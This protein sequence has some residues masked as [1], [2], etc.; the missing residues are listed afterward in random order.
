M[1]QQGT[2]M[3]Q[4]G[5]A[6]GS[7]LAQQGYNAAAPVLQQGVVQGTALAQQGTAQ[8]SALAQQGYNAA[9]P[10]L[11]QGVAQGSAAAVQA[12]NHAA[13]IAVA[14]GQNAISGGQSLY[15]QAVP[16]INKAGQQVSDGAKLVYT[17]AKPHAIELADSTKDVLSNLE[18]PKIQFDVNAAKNALGM[19][20]GMGMLAL[21]AAA[22]GAQQAGAWAALQNVDILKVEIFRDFFQ[23]L[24]IYFSALKLPNGFKSFYGNV[25]NFISASFANISLFAKAMTPINWFLVFFLVMTVC[26]LVLFSKMDL[27]INDMIKMKKTRDKKNWKEMN[28]KDGKRKYKIIKAMLFVLTSLYVPVTRNCMDVLFCSPTYAYSKWE[29]ID[30]ATGKVLHDFYA[31]PNEVHAPHSC[32]DHYEYLPRP[33]AASS[34]LATDQTP[35]PS[36]V[37]A[38]TAPSAAGPASFVPSETTTNASNASNA[39]NPSASPSPSATKTSSPSPVAATTAPSAAGPVSFVP[40][41]TCSLC[42]SGGIFSGGTAAKN[43]VCQHFCSSAINGRICGTAPVHRAQGMM[44]PHCVVAYCY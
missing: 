6:Q 3:A 26:W 27:K 7:A 29:C 9:A 1:A 21:G 30:N 39:S 38:T 18:L 15:K 41:E 24:G 4:Q 8:G 17:V 35:S 43:G 40:S 25:S 20:G 13:P 33:V 10:V 28:R 23:F 36:S 32:V 44:H 14:A 11:Q 37:A 12:Y 42:K 22:S 2:A 19:A 5:A 34:I 31:A 16:H